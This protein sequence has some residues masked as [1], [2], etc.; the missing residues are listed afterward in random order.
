MRR[1]LWLV[2][3]LGGC[4]IRLS[5]QDILVT[6]TPE[7]VAIATVPTATFSAKPVQATPGPAPT[8]IPATSF[9]ATEGAVTTFIKLPADATPTFSVGGLK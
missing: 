8:A 3:L 9:T 1:A 2:L 5:G 7:P 4:T 6:K